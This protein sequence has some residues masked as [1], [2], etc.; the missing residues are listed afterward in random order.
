LKGI[1]TTIFAYGQT[2]AGKTSSNNTKLSAQDY[3]ETYSTII[4]STINSNN[5]VATAQKALDEL[6][7]TI[8]ELNAEA[9][10]LQDECYQ[11]SYNADKQ[12]R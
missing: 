6:K 11:L 10:R 12:N 2:G 3:S 7:K 8:T 5:S 4:E 9:K 1:N